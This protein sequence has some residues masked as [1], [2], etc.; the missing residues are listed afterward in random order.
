MRLLCFDAFL[1][2]TI[3]STTFAPLHTIFVPF[4]FF[5]KYYDFF[6]IIVNISGNQ[7]NLSTLSLE[8]FKV[9][10]VITCDISKFTIRNADIRKRFQV[11]YP[12][13]IFIRLWN[14]STA[15]E[16]SFV[17][18][19][20]AIIIRFSGLLKVFYFGYLLL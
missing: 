9:V 5:V 14:S 4:S 15:S 7:G 19:F 6:N 12:I 20:L 8:Y 17:L 13:G 18:L 16:V 1:F 2:S 3:D 10:I 11:F